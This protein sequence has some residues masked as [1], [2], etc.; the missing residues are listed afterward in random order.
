M[1]EVVV[2]VHPVAVQ[3]AEDPKRGNEIFHSWPCRGRSS[4]L[5]VKV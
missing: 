1:E 4:L 3:V 5:M 2:V